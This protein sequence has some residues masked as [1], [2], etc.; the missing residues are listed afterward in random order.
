MA[1]T[2]LKQ[3]AFLKGAREVTL[4][5]D[6]SVLVKIR[7]KGTYT[8]YSVALNTLDDSPSRTQHGVAKSLF[9][10]GSFSLLLS[11]SLG[12]AFFAGTEESRVT[13]GIFSVLFVFPFIWALHRMWAGSYDVLTF[14]NR[15][16]GQSVF[17]LFYDK[18]TPEAF[19]PFIA[20]L[21]K[22]TKRV[23]AETAEA[24]NVSIPNQIQ[25]FARLRDQ[26]ILTAEEFQ[27]VKSRLLATIDQGTG[28]IGF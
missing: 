26:G 2:T 10:V 25:G 6:D 27:T 7:H 9:A 1:D 23:Q 8:E 5:T 20:A 14:F 3:S 13:L 12:G 19:K 17:N 22:Q 16:S 21:I 24:E 18:P 28:R 11:G 15:F 4:N